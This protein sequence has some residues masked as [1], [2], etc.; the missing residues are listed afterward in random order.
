MTICL[1]TRKTNNL[2]DDKKNSESLSDEKKGN[3][4][5]LS[6]DRKKPM[7]RC[8]TTVLVMIENL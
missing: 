2:F 6:D 1:M 4:D 8:P 5:I 3:K 7:T